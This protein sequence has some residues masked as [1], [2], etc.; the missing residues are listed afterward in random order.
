MTYTPGPGG[1]TDT[2]I[3]LYDGAG[4]PVPLAAVLVG[5]G[6]WALATVDIGARQLLEEILLELKTLNESRL[7]THDLG[8]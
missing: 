2:T 7:E 6:Q 4:T 5:P 1:I 8:R 3:V